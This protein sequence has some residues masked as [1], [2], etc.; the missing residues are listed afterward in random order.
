MF[1]KERK[2]KV[3]NIFVIKIDEMVNAMLKNR[4]EKKSDNFL[5]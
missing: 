2:L 5:E 3:L 1:F 4:N